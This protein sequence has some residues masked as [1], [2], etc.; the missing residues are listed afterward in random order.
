[1]KGIEIP[2]IETA[3]LASAHVD[4]EAT[5]NPAQAEADQNRR[6]TPNQYLQESVLR[7]QVVRELVTYFTSTISLLLVVRFRHSI[8]LVAP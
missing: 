6:T 5:T 7:H 2:A 4:R 3:S 1:M 8:H